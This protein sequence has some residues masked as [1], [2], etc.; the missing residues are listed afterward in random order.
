MNTT[1]LIPIDRKTIVRAIQALNEIEHD[2]RTQEQSDAKLALE[3]R[4]Q[5]IE[6]IKKDNDNK[7]MMDTDGENRPLRCFLMQYGQP[8]LTVGTMKKH[9][10]M[11]GYPYWPSWVNDKAATTHLTKGGAQSWIRHLLSL[12]HTK[13]ST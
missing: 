12:E 6:E 10:T 4:L 9:M 11:C 7:K 8:S 5:E 2:I 3:S 13:E 1:E